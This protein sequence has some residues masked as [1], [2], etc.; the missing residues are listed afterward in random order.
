VSEGHRVFNFLFAYLAWFGA[1]ILT[2]FDFLL[3]RAVI[4]QWYVILHLPANA[5]KAVDRF[6][7]FFGSAIWIFLIFFIE[8]YFRQG[9]LEA[10]LGSRL[11]VI[12]ISSAAFA[13]MMACLLAAIYL[14]INMLALRELL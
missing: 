6:Y 5:H 11:K 3:L 13:L 14:Y 2:A 4:S 1:I 9:V 7:L 10:N 8:G 12:Y